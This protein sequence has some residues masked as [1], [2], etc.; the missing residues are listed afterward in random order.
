MFMMMIEIV[1]ARGRRWCQGVSV[2]GEHPVSEQNERVDRLLERS[3]P[4]AVIDLVGQEVDHFHH[5]ATRIITSL[6]VMMLM[7]MV[8]A[9]VYV[10]C[11]N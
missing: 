9:L 8:V 7:M 10:L 1:L 4:K 6:T 11:V 5:H 2:I 3:V